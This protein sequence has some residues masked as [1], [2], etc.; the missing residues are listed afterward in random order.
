LNENERNNIGLRNVK[1][2]L[3]LLYPESHELLINE[4]ENHF[5]IYLKIVD[6]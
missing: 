5:G 2:R 1:S 4:Q 3:Q 6:L